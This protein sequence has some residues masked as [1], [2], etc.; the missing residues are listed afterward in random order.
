M[1]KLGIS[2]LVVPDGVSALAGVQALWW[3][4]VAVALIV[5]GDGAAVASVEG[6]AANERASAA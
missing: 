4:A 6:R 2:D 5:R 3:L 1:G